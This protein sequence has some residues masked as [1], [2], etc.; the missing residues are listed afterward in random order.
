MIVVTD[1]MNTPELICFPEDDIGRVLDVINCMPLLSGS[2]P[3]P[4]S[5]IGGVSIL[6]GGAWTAPRREPVTGELSTTCSTPFNVIHFVPECYSHAAFF[7]FF[8]VS[9]VVYI[10]SFTS[11]QDIPIHISSSAV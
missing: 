5:S 9:V 8:V 6:N 3:S 2:V 4:V 10:N 7:F 1:C 11:E